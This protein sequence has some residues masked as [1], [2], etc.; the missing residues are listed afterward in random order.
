MCS[1]ERLGQNVLMTQPTFH[2]KFELTRELYT[3]NYMCQ[4]YFTCTQKSTNFSSRLNKYSTTNEYH[5][6]AHHRL[7]STHLYTYQ[8]GHDRGLRVLA[9]SLSS[10]WMWPGEGRRKYKL[11]LN[12]ITQRQHRQA[13][14]IFFV[15]VNFTIFRQTKTLNSTFLYIFTPMSS[16]HKILQQPIL[17][18]FK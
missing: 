8:Y 12:P 2:G 4:P 6:P 1:W 14:L 16:E 17:M 11:L 15:C 7:W 18:F 10:F 3:V 13:I 9:T 5:Y